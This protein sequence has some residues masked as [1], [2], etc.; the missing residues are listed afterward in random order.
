MMVIFVQCAPMLWQRSPYRVRWT[1][2][3]QEDDMV[4]PFLFNETEYK[5]VKDPNPNIIN[6]NKI[7]IS[8]Q[9]WLKIT[10]QIW[11]PLIFALIPSAHKRITRIDDQVYCTLYSVQCS[12]VDPNVLAGSESEKKVRIQTLLKD[13]NFCEIS[14][15]KH[16][17]EK[18]LMFFY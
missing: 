17:K 7:R 12:V 15:I 13:E 11:N 10:V 14:K 1:K 4:L 3:G 5:S 9:G 2:M 6:Q 8:I 18:N 16:L